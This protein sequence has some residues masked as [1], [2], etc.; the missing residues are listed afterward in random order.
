M[1]LFDFSSGKVK[2][3]SLL[4]LVTCFQSV[5]AGDTLTVSNDFYSIDHQLKLVLINQDISQLN[6]EWT[7]QTDKI[8]LDQVYSI[9]NQTS[10]TVGSAYSISRAGS[11]YTLYLSQLPVIKI[12]T[13]HEIV[14]EPKV[15]AF[16][17]LVEINGDVTETDIGIELR[18]QTSLSFAKKNYSIEC[19]EDA[20]GEEKEELQFL[21]M[22]ENEDWNLMAMYNEPLRINNAVAHEFWREMHKPHYQ[23]SEPAAING[24]RMEY[25]EVFIN[26]NY[27]GVFGLGEKVDRSQLK[28]KKYTPGTIKGELY[29]GDTWRAGVMY[30][31][32]I[33]YD[34]NSVLW[35]GFEYEYPK[36]SVNWSNLYNFIDFVKNSSKADFMREY[37]SRF[38]V[39]NAIDYFIFVN[40][41]NASDNTGKNLF[42]AKYKAGDP[43]FYVPWDLDGVFGTYRYG[44]YDYTTRGILSNRFYQRLLQDD[45]PNG[46]NEKL[47]NRWQELRGT[48]IKEEHILPMFQSKHDLLLSNGIYAREKMVWPEFNYDNAYQ[49]DM[50][51]DWL[52]QRIAYLDD[53]FS[54]DKEELFDYSQDETRTHTQETMMYPNP[55]KDVLTIDVPSS[56]YY[57]DCIITDVYGK[58]LFNDKLTEFSNTID[59]AFWPTGLYRVKI[60]KGDAKEVLILMCTGI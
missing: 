12:T 34:N 14:N 43:Y 17:T 15:S 58:V 11:Q 37:A 32:L 59:T 35:S 44:N 36:D 57:G 4:L 40:L 2:I 60:Q 19:W 13:P 38:D 41:L 50:I 26:G 3:A 21:S 29:V 18:G 6:A 48:L 39:K 31:A 10:L 42:I 46:F 55:A 16:F 25:T 24:I 47:K 51:S 53:F 9:N 7:T 8:Q 22:R 23:A 30:N 52:P 20:S 33:P 56:L 45:G 28:L 1:A 54:R 5:L 49:L 27:K